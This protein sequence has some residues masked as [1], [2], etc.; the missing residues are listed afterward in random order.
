[1]NECSSARE[2]LLGASSDVSDGQVSVV[3]R[4]GGAT[5]LFVDATAGGQGTAELH[6]YTFVSLADLEKVAVSGDGSLES[7]QWDLA[8]KRST[9]YTNGGDGGPGQ[10]GAVLL[11]KDFASVT[12]ADTNGIELIPERFFDA[13]CNPNVG[14]TGSVYTDLADWY[15]Y[16]AETH[17]LSPNSG[18]YLVR[19]AS[20]AWFKVQFQDYYATENGG[21]NANGG[22]Y[23]LD[24]EA[25]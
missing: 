24:V 25:L 14:I 3:S 22:G 21:K 6:P 15:A 8:F 13:D 2:Q 17:V 9:V 19:S 18:T 5:R 12:R 16:D 23:L 11:D 10:G 1:M 4:T 20:G 7:V